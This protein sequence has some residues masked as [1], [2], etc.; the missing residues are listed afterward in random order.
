M[1][2]YPLF[3]RT[4]AVCLPRPVCAVEA[5][6]VREAIKRGTQYL[7]REQRPDGSWAGFL[8]HD[9]TGL[10]TLAL[11]QAGV[12]PEDPAIQKALV[13]PAQSAAQGD[14][15]NGLADDGLLR[16]R[17]EAGPAADPPQRRLVREDADQR[18]KQ[19]GAWAYPGRGNGDN[20][21]SQFALL[22]LHEAERAGVSVKDETWRM[23]LAYWQQAQ[24]IDGSFGY[25]AGRRGSASMTCAGITSL[26]IASGRLQEG[27]AGVDGERVRCCADR[28][29]TIRSSG[30]SHWLGQN[31]SV[32]QNTG[33]SGLWL[34]YYLYGVERVGRM[35]AHRFLGGH[36]W[37]R[38]GSEMLVGNQD[39]LSGFWK[40]TGHVED[41]PYI[42]T[43]L[44]LL[45]LAKGRRP[46][47]MGRLKHGPAGSDD[48]NHHRNS[49]TPPDQLRRDANGSGTS[50]GR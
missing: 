14:V 34:L 5:E 28:T 16:G 45:F 24:N 29:P 47:L 8:K 49:L 44:S 17:A 43:S 39:Q 30:P 26:V 1:A 3:D 10:C 2:D 18:R 9:L 7:L 12:K 22:A 35:T 41:N 25:S 33:G 13:V 4:A 37:Y 23:A 20:S 19:Q 46:V 32:H 27:D 48:W 36:D 6:Q 11:L 40:G 21:N 50:P 38:E 31:F 15:R 42:G